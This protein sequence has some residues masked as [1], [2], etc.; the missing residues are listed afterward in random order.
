MFADRT[1]GGVV[2]VR[3]RAVFPRLQ[4]RRQDLD[5]LRGVAGAAVLFESSG[6]GNAARTLAAAVADTAA[7][8]VVVVLRLWPGPDGAEILRHQCAEQP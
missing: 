3:C 7:G 8:H 1:G 2:G 4:R 6:A 5:G